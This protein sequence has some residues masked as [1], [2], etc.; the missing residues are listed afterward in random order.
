MVEEVITIR[1]EVAQANKS[2]ESVAKKTEELSDK[3]DNVG[4]QATQ[5]ADNMGKMAKAVQNVNKRLSNMGVAIKASGIAL[6]LSAFGTIKEAFSQTQ[7][8]ADLGATVFNTLTFAVSNLVTAFRNGEVN[9]LNFFEV[10]SDSFSK[11]YEDGKKMV[12]LQNELALADAIRAYEQL[13]YQTRAEKLRQLRDDESKDIR[14]RIEANEQLGL[15]L[16]DQLQ[17]E[18]EL[19]QKKVDQAK[20]QYDINQSIPN[21]IALWNALTE[22]QDIQERITGQQ[23]EQLTNRNAL[24]REEREIRKQINEASEFNVYSE[25][26]K[27]GVALAEQ[28]IEYAKIVY[29]EKAAQLDKE[30]ELYEYGTS[31]YARVLS[32]RYDLDDNYA[33]NSILLEKNLQKAKTDVA[34]NVLSSFIAIAEEGSDLQKGLAVAQATWNTYEAVTAALGAKPYGPWN[35][36]QAVATGLFGIA[37]VRK[38]IQTQAPTAG[39]TV[40]GGSISGAAFQPASVN[41]PGQSGINSIIS[42]LQ[43]NNQAIKAYV[44]TGE[45]TSGQEL[46]RKR[47]NNAT[48]G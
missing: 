20:A 18:Q 36:A 38:I 37:Q 6:L 24:L 35:I 45:V 12:K 48:F 41:I 27:T 2:I 46:E 44:V 15:L 9:A 40:S 28:E 5:A 25:R 17:K 22:L 23:S 4:K 14:T 19:A 3:V 13:E 47:L 42:G 1:A 32:E 34:K 33:K 26:A 43:N 7:E 16:D 21:Q 29:D 10:L 11:A 31:E 39:G 8:I 30:L